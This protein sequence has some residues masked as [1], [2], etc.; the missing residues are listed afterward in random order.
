MNLKK[1]EGWRMRWDSNMWNPV[2]WSAVPIMPPT[3]SPLPLLKRSNKGAFSLD[4]TKKAL[5]PANRKK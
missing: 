3:F 5:L 2:P 1:S 4:I